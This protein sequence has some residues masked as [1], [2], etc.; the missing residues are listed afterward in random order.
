[1][2]F[3]IGEPLEDQAWKEMRAMQV[4]QAKESL[5]FENLLYATDFQGDSESALPYVFS[6]AK[7]YQSK[8]YVVHVVDVSPFSNPSPTSAMRAVEAQAIRE[9]KQAALELSPAL[10]PVPSEVLIRKGDIWKE[11][12]HVIEEKNIDLIVV[13]THGR[14]GI[15]KLVLGSV[16]ERIFRRAPCPVLTV[17][18]GVHGETDPFGRLHSILV[19]TDFTPESRVAVSYA[20][21]LAQVHQSRVYLLHVTHDANTRVASV[22]E[23][24]GKLIP[25]DI[26]L[27]FSPKTFVEAGV[28]SE[29]ILDLAA[30]LAVDLIVLGVKPPA[31]LKGTS[32]HQNMA[33][34]SKVVRGAGCPVITVRT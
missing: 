9:A 7:A 27:P 30:E 1:M 5:R 26:D 21:A 33:T 2:K 32:T 18:P 22:K 4:Q 12:S 19:P 17:G 20:S 34:A 29:K 14:A 28:P 31:I 13:G 11:I 25:R 23:A 16:A 6:V 8:V 24:L 15:H 3:R 10:V